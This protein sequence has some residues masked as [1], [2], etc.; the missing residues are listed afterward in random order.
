MAVHVSL[1]LKHKTIFRIEAL[2]PLS[3]MLREKNPT[4]LILLLDRCVC[5]CVI[6]HDYYY[7]VQYEA[8][9]YNMIQY[10]NI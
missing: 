1:Y 4:L 8:V 7:I 5:C 2:S 9:W 3:G 6:Y 10:Y